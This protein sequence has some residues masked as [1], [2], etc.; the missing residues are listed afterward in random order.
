MSP[1]H[2]TVTRHPFL[3]PPP[4]VGAGE[5][6]RGVERDEAAADQARPDVQ[7]AG[8]RVGGQGGAA[9]QKVAEEP[10]A[11]EYND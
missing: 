5:A 6:P 11:G 10:D 7:D 8:G 3:S 1:V 9:H 2:Y 4:A